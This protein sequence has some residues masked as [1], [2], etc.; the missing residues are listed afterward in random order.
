MRQFARA[1][2][3]ITRGAGERFVLE[4][5]NIIPLEYIRRSKGLVTMKAEAITVLKWVLVIL[6]TGFVAQF[7]KMF[8]Q[9]L[10]RRVRESRGVAAM[11]PAAE[12]SPKMCGTSAVSEAERQRLKMEKKSR[13]A[14]IKAGKKGG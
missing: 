5:F 2:N 14:E 12:G 9:Y 3:I 10:V 6:A 4:L 1:V 8:A 11:P 13:K 7:G